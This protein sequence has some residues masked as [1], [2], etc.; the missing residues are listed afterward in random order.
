VLA[1]PGPVARRSVTQGLQVR[2]VPL[3][4]SVPAE[5]STAVDVDVVTLQ[6]RISNRT[7]E[8]SR[9]EVFTDLGW[10]PTHSRFVHAVLMQESLLVEPGDWSG[11]VLIP[12]DTRFYARAA[13]LVEPGADRSSSIAEGSFLDGFDLADL[14][15]GGYVGPPD[16]P[17]VHGVERLSL[18]PQ[19]GLLC[20]PD[21]AWDGAGGD[22]LL[23]RQ[24][25]LLDVPR[26][27]SVRAVARWRAQVDSSFAAA[28]HPWLGVVVP[29]DPLG[30]AQLVP[31]SA[32]AAGIIA[33]REVRLG[34]PWG[35][36]NEVAVGAVTAAD[37]VSDAE[38]DAL[39]LLDVDTFRRERDGWR[40][41]S[42]RTLSTDPAYRQLSV[43]RLMTMLRLVID[44]QLQWLVFE[45]HT[46]QLR[47]VVTGVVTRLL[48]EL[49]RAGAFAGTTEDEA[50]FVRCDDSVNPEWST[51][52]GRIVAEIGVAPAE[53]LEYLVLRIRQDVDGALAVTG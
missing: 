46:P 20:V 29:D 31:P 53:P 39:H 17:I 49:F 38:H 21:L 15:V 48:R 24:L 35:P 11:E 28:Y 5:V 12:P 2:V 6:V 47:A 34:L 45:P 4:G 3:G 13:R 50:F 41:V 22:D 32:F 7:E 8:L 26:H 10:D 37:P 27:Q 42:A 19:I 18:V 51:G 36:A 43:R 30:R 16:E 44:R 23:R 14:P 25:R 40:L 1:W 9:E 52:Q 33:S